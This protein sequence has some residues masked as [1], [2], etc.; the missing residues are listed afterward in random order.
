M[1][2]ILKKISIAGGGGSKKPKP[3]IYKPPV[4][5]ELQYGASYSY[6]ETLDLISDGPIEGLVNANGETVD[7]L[8]MLQGIYLD[9]T[10]VAVTTDSPRE[11]DQLTTL[12]AETIETLNM[13]L[14]GTK[15]VA[16]CSEFFQELK[17][18]ARRSADGKITTLNSS[19]AGGPDNDEASSNVDVAMVFVRETVT[20][21]IRRG[22]F[23]H[24]G[25]ANPTTPLVPAQLSDYGLY[26]RGFIKYRGAAG[27]QTFQWY[28]NGEN[29][30][31]YSD[32]NAAF[33]DD[34][35]SKG[36]LG[37]L[38]WA[39]TTLASSKFIFSFQPDLTYLWRDPSFS[40]SLL[41]SGKIFEQNE[42]RINEVAFPELNTIYD[43]YANNNQFG[44]NIVQKDLA[45]RA[46][47]R[48]GFSM[49]NANAVNLLQDYLNPE[50]YGGVI[51]VKVEDSNSN[52]NKSILDGND[53]FNMTTFPVGSESGFNLIAVMENAGMRVT[54][55]TCPEIDSNG[56]L[57][58]VMHGF[59]IFEFPILNDPIET[60][61]RTDA[62]NDY[63]YGNAYTYTIPRAVI[64]ALS[65]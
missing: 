61:V 36:T 37:S 45:L 3:P 10:A 51:I 58:G 65:D 39:D 1:K 19:T 7:G 22:Q 49:G 4:M 18:A 43:L 29:Q 64:T 13:E 23:G 41:Q 28:L 24:A 53:L 50:E 2:H 6:A 16:F 17:E 55:V 47:K 59:L 32:S 20:T 63:P 38:L 26:I 57:T 25:V 21:H 54:D 34:N 8:K 44:G 27:A 30:T 33:R 11:L 5:G 14:D 42:E 56:T 35:R 52:L 60:V 46:L 31:G 12:E 40:R 9:D 62:G 15:G 48:L